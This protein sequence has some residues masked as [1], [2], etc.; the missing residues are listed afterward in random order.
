MSASNAR[1]PERLQTP[2]RGLVRAK[3]AAG[4]VSLVALAGMFVTSLHRAPNP[5]FSTL[6]AAAALALAVAMAAGVWR[7]RRR[8]PHRR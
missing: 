8:P 7:R 1:D 5:A 2:G 6:T 3:W 4:A